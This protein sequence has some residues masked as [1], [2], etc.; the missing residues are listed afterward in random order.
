MDQKNCFVLEFISIVDYLVEVCPNSIKIHKNPS[1]SMKHRNNKVVKIS[2]LPRT[3]ECAHNLLHV[4]LLL[5][6]QH[7][8]SAYD[9]QQ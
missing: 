6:Y 7:R 5:N 9:T 4:P 1:C 2:P 3:N 8:Y